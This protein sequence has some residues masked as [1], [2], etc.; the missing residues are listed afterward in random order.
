MLPREKN[1]KNSAIWGNL[2]VPKYAITSLNINN[3]NDKSTTTK[4]N[5]HNFLLDQSRG[6]PSKSRKS[7]NLRLLLHYFLLFSRAP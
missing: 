3:F 4:L 2:D 5:C 1:D 6:L 7:N